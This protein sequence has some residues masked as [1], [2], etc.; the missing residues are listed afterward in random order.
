MPVL[1]AGFTI[2]TTNLW[3]IFAAD[4]DPI[5]QP[6][7]PLSKNLETWARHEHDQSSHWLKV[8][9]EESSEV[10]GGGRC[11]VYKKRKESPYDGHGAIE[12]S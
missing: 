1:R 11:A 5:P 8:V 4:I 6:Q 12:A 10:L 9:D 3:P 2:P 7:P